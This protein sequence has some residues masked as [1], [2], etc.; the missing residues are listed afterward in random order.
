ML[1]LKLSDCLI[2]VAV[3]FL[4]LR[5]WFGEKSFKIV[6]GPL[7]GVLDLVREVFQCTKR[8]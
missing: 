4:E 6:S 8:D 5:R 3:E 7:N 1:F 2:M